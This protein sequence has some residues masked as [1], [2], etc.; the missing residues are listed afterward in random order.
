M[1]HRK[2][3]H[4]DMDCF[5]A[6]IECRDDPSVADQPVG[7]GGS[8]GRGVLTTCN[9]RAREFGCRSAMPVFQALQ[10]CPSL[11][12]KP[13]RAEVY[14]RESARIRAIFRDYTDL[15]EPLSLDEAFLDVSARPERA[16]VLAKEIRYRIREEIGLSASAGVAPNKMLAKI[17]SD[18]RKP[19][20]Q[21]AILPA[22][23]EAFMRDLPVG[24]IPGIGPK[25]Q[26]RLRLH[27]VETCGDLQSI[28]RHQLIA[29]F[30]ASWANELEE[31]ARGFDDSPVQANRVRKSF[32]SEHT[33]FSP[34]ESLEAC[35]RELARMVLELREDLSTK[36]KLPPMRK[37]FV[38]VK[39]SD[40]RS[41]TRERPAET[42]SMEQALELL[43]EAYGRSRHAVRLLGC[44]VRFST[45]PENDSRQ[46]VFSL[47]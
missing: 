44:G 18:W 15:V 38:K 32:S 29:W 19:D 10:R 46:L 27:D 16:W 11:I 45:P 34:L 31:R 6:A 30:G 25:A 13:I 14:S 17:A 4:L 24:R 21:F 43:G 7:V 3:I 5:Y 36:R 22:E 9:Y 35:Q 37:L 33:F 1:L 8:G 42:V 26:E 20:G 12:I 40:F 41:T 23:I 47:D 28:P 2:I 39:F